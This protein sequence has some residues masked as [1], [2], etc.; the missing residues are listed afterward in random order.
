MDLF[1]LRPISFILWLHHLEPGASSAGGG[2]WG[3]GGGQGKARGW[4]QDSDFFM[5]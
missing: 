4:D 2:G 5:S 1:T 3:E